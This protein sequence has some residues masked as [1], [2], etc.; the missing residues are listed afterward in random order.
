MK[1]LIS[2]LLALMLALGMT[3]ALAEDAETPTFICG[4][5]FNMNM[6]Q[7]QE[8]L[9]QADLNYP[10]FDVEHTRSGLAFEQLEYEHAVDENGRGVDIRFSFIGNSMIAIHYDMADGVRYDDIRADLVSSFGE[11]VPFSPEKIGNARFVI[12]DDGD[13]RN[14]REMFEGKGMTIVLE[15]DHDED[16]DITIFD[17]TAAYINN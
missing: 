15:Q 14:C 4:V 3:A 13:L 16:V 17:P 8:L 11:P 9:A 5:Q 10:E 2:A 6:D 1:K 7:V 12:D